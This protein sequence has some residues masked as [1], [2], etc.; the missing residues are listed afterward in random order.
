MT[1]R[2][3]TCIDCRAAGSAIAA[4]LI[5]AVGCG[6][7]AQVLPAPNSHEKVGWKTEDYFDDPQ[8]VALCKAI[9]ANDLAEIDRLVA[10]GADVNA[11]GKGKM[12]PLLWAFPDNKLMR[13][14]R[15]LEHG[16]DPNVVVEDEFNTRGVVMPGDSVTH[17]AAS[18]YYPGYFEAVF[19]HGG[20]PNLK[21]TSVLGMDDTPL[22]SSSSGRAVTP[23]RK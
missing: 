21:R 5:A 6:R 8:V 7:V 10:A 20:D 16:A 11:Q 1:P 22:F 17:M 13:F 3:K 19:A 15:L 4:L 12:T 18:S 2:S 9:E 14:K 23:L